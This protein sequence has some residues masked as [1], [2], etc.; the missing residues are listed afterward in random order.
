VVLL[1][2]AVRMHQLTSQ[3]LWGA[4][5]LQ[6]QQ[7]A[8][9]LTTLLSGQ[10]ASDA[11]YSAGWTGPLFS[12]LLAA[13]QVAL[14][15]ANELGR[16]AA[17]WLG[18]LAV[19]LIYRLGREVVGVRAGMGAA[20]LLALSPIHV[21]FSQ[22]VGPETA[23]VLFSL[24]AALALW[25][26]TEGRQ[27]RRVAW[28]TLTLA[29]AGLALFVLTI[30]APGATSAFAAIS[31][32]GQPARA[33]GLLAV[34]IA[35]GLSYQWWR[36][37]PMLTLALAGAVAYWRRGRRQVVFLLAY[38]LVPLIAWY[39]LYRSQP[40]AN[41]LWLVLAGLPPLLVLAAAGWLYP[42]RSWRGRALGLGLLLITLQLSWLQAQSY[43]P[44][45]RK[46]DIRALS[47]D[48]QG[49][50]GEDDRIVLTDPGLSAAFGRYYQGSAPWTI[51]DR[52]DVADLQW[53]LQEGQ[54]LWLVENAQGAGPASVED[55]SW[56]WLRQWNYDGLWNSWV[57]SAF[58]PAPA[59]ASLPE[60][61][62]PA[63]VDWGGELTL[64]GFSVPSQGKSGGWWQ[65]EFYWRKSAAAAGQY[66]LYLRLVDEQGRTWTNDG[67]LLWHSYPPGFWPAETLHVE[68]P[69]WRLPG[70]LPPGEYQAWLQVVR[71]EDGQLLP[72][73]SGGTELLL[74]PRLSLEP[75]T[76]P[77]DLPYLPG[78]KR[79]DAGFGQDLTLLGYRVATDEV[80]RP[81]HSLPVTLFW[82]ADSP[83]DPGYRL[84]LQLVNSEDEILQQLD[85]PVYAGAD[86]SKSWPDGALLTTVSDLPIPA[87]ADGNHRIIAALLPPGSEEPMR[88]GGLFGSDAVQL[89]DVFVEP[90]PM[91][92]ALPPMETT[93]RADFGEPSAIELHGYML[94]PA[95]GNPGQPATLT[96][97]W[98]ASALMDE[99]YV[100]FVHLVDG[101][102]NVVAQGD[103]APLN[104]FRPTSSW[105]PGEV[106]VDAHTF[107]LPE[108]LADGPYTLWIG[109]Y[110]PVS[111]TRLP[112]F[113][114][115]ERQVDDRLKLGGIEIEP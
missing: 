84:R 80:Y 19:P 25:R 10:P 33:A 53:S 76:A 34:G 100:V 48:L 71:T 36:Y 90:W 78:H 13:L 55:A 114:N 32:G 49:L 17:L 101:Q 39:L 110:E 109:L 73:S 62:A 82:Q 64:A 5:G 74:R 7:A 115:G 27:A 26:V 79:V 40:A 106:F 54:L 45:L 77:D 18:V 111:G 56:P 57:V 37:A 94:E 50:A 93:L 102:G 42:W 22:E 63:N 46:D 1:A 14:G 61:I 41:C 16:V 51:I 58:M 35:P 83:P 98:R 38:L 6:L 31:P 68:R 75:A 60:N 11:A 24:L 86:P 91:E 65:P 113:V 12:L 107:A 97:Y 81:G 89:A 23:L 21:W 59:V 112:V 99:N 47:R 29:G 15:D 3:S 20:L 72:A 85:E 67:E 88:A 108:N 30:P 104:G 66:T 103:G 52:Q 28:L 4:E 95:V 8:Q 70:G 9:P 105:R 96:L 2:F 69:L 44:D 87:V 43:S 92:T